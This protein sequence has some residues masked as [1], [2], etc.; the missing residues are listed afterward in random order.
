MARPLTLA[1]A[2]ALSLLFVSGAGGSPAQTPKRGGTVVLATSGGGGPAQAEPACLNVV[3]ASCR[4][5]NLWLGVVG[6][7]LEGAYDIGPDLT[8]RPRLARATFT[9][10]PPF[11]LTYRIRPEARW[12]DGTP[13]SAADFLFTHRT[14]S[15]RRAH[16]PEPVRLLIERVRS[17][18]AVDQK[19]V[20]VVLRARVAVWQRLFVSVLPRHVLRGLD[21][22]RVWL[23]GLDDPRTGHSIGSGPW[24]VGSWERGRQLTLVR[25]PRFWGEH[26]AYLDR[27]VLRFRLEG[28]T[29]LEWLR[30][31]EVDV[32]GPVP[33]E[34]LVELGRQPGVRTL[35]TPL[36]S[37]EHFALRLGPGGHP[38][39]RSKLVRR[40]L[41][42]GLDRVALAREA[43]GAIDPRYPVSDSAVF[44]LGSRH[45]HPTWRGYRHRP[46]HARRLLEQAGCR[47]GGD[48]VY[49]CGRD[50]LSLRFVTN[51]GVSIRARV[52]RLA[53]AQLRGVGVEVVPEYLPSVAFTGPGGAIWRGDFDVAQFAWLYG[54]DPLRKPIFGCG[55]EENVMGYCQRLATR[56]LDQLDLILDP[57]RQARVGRRVD[58]LLARDVPVI[59]LYQLPDLIARRASIRNFVVARG[60]FVPSMQHAEEWWLDR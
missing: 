8:W 52:L 21:L 17:V 31:G 60:G 34:Q 50:R 12:S 42:F 35:A 54:P 36:S 15:A 37:W 3:L 20:R 16:L 57:G 46:A 49:V 44:L 53:Q 33:P 11:T 43:F 58:A 9:T 6:K 41:A 22:D 19:T 32:V 24:L 30:R 47:L 23:D 38:A 26:T 51:A 55:G 7:V 29:P 2:I 59:P 1:A 18:R 13:V 5:S 27:L 40:A 28:S 48:G 4:P 39:L 14:F 45:Y 10:R 56:D 25:N